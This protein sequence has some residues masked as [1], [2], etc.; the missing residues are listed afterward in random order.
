MLFSLWEKLVVNLY[1]LD[2]EKKKSL[3]WCVLLS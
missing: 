1:F 2:M 3:R